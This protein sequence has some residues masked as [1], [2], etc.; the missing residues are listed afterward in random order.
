MF[1][2]IFRIILF[3]A[4]ILVLILWIRWRMIKV[5]DGENLDQEFKKVRKYIL[6]LLL[7]IVLAIVGLKLT[8]NETA[9]AGAQYIP[10]RLEDGKVIP[11]KFKDPK[12]ENQQDDG[13]GGSSKDGSNKDGSN[14]DG[15]K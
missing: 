2:L 10:P 9:N 14:K 5:Q 6:G 1:A 8:E 7:L 3:L 4:P 13:K 15:R 11:G 12:E